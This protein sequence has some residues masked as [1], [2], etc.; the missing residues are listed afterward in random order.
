MKPELPNPAEC[1]PEEH[2]KRA[3]RTE[4]IDDASFERA[5]AIFRA[6]GDVARLKLLERLSD[7]EWCVT[8]L[9]AAAGVGLSTV[10][11]QLRLLRSEDLVK[12]RRVGKHVFYALADKHVAELIHNALDHA[13]EEP[14]HPHE[15]EE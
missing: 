13:V 12:R 2:T 6:A 3:R 1:A 11:Q 14:S 4:P 15:H 9:A 7:G 5:A 8:E 10:S